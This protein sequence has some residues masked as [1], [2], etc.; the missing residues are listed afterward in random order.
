[1]VFHFFPIRIPPF[2]WL[3]LIFFYGS[4]TSRSFLD[5]L[6]RTSPEV[7]FP[8]LKS[9]TFRGLASLWILE[10]EI[11]VLLAIFLLADLVSNL[12]ENF[13]VTLLDDS[14]ALIIWLIILTTAK[15]Y[16]VNNCYMKLT[17]WSLLVDIGVESPVIPICI[18]FSNLRPHLFSPHILHGLGLLFGRPLKVD[19]ATSIGPLVPLVQLGPENFGYIQHV[20]MEDFSP[21]CAQ[22]KCIEHLKGYYRPIPASVPVTVNAN[23]TNPGNANVSSNGNAIGVL[24]I[25]DNDACFANYYCGG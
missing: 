18:S 3:I 8:D 25:L 1:M 11:L 5:A 23:A 6:S 7:C 10:E 20:V 14:H 2:G 12:F 17:K 16:F 15:S 22:C 4:I 19:N 21:F 13:L 9:T 24:E